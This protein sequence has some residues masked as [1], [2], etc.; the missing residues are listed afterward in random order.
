MSSDGEFVE[1][2]IAILIVPIKWITWQSVFTCLT[3]GLLI[4]YFSYSFHMTFLYDVIDRNVTGQLVP[5][6]EPLRGSSR[7]EYITV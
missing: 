5:D 4:T 7:I 3:H 2:V 1:I 6:D